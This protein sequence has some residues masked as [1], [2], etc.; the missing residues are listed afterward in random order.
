[1]DYNLD[2]KTSV[3][4]SN[5]RSDAIFVHCVLYLHGTLL[6]IWTYAM[7]CAAVDLLYG[8]KTLFWAVDLLYGYETLFW[9][10]NLLYGYK[11]LWAAVDLLYEYKTVEFLV[12]EKKI[13]SA[14]FADLGKSA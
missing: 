9:A 4:V 5:L 7:G 12:L 11:I 1:L 6:Y 14:Q 3:V 8:Y 10:V 2:M 13:Q